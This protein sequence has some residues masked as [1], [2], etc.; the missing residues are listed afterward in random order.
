MLHTLLITIPYQYAVLS[1]HLPKRSKIKFLNELPPFASFPHQSLHN[2]SQS[3]VAVDFNQAIS[4]EKGG[5]EK[6]NEVHTFASSQTVIF[7]ETN[8]ETVTGAIYKAINI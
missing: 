8:K 6:R 2:S 1:E 4:K 7:R 5:C 3:T